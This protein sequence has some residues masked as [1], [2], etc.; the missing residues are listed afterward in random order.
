MPT[1]T[2]ALN[3]L[4]IHRCLQELKAKHNVVLAQF[5]EAQADHTKEVAQ[6][7]EREHK[8]REAAE[9]A[10]SRRLQ[11]QCENSAAASIQAHWRGYKIRQGTKGGKDKGKK[12]KKKK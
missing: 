11:D 1:R 3:S 9:L 2:A 4:S 5:K 8:A 7:Q 10:E 12:G 6:K